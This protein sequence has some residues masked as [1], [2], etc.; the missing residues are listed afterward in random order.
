MLLRVFPTMTVHV[1]G[2]A[3]VA[4]AVQF[5]MFLIMGVKVVSSPGICI[6][7]PDVEGALGIF[8]GLPFLAFLG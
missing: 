6:P 4:V 1:P 7:D 2:A 5:L 8:L 3:L